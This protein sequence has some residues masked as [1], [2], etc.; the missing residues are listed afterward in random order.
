MWYQGRDAMPSRYLSG[1]ERWQTLHPEYEYVFWDEAAI[2]ALLASSYSEYLPRW[3][4]IDKVIKKCD[5]ARYFI[6]HHCG[7]VYADLDTLPYRSIDE[8]LADFSL[9]DAPIVL[10]EESQDPLVWKGPLGKRIRAERGLQKIVGNA[11]LLSRRGQ[12]FWLDFLDA[13]F[14][15]G[16]LPVLESF[17]TWHLSEFIR[18]Y[19]G[20]DQLAVVPPDHLL[21]TRFQAGTTYV[22]HGYD[23]TWFDYAKPVPWEG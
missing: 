16:D 17:S 13:S 6:L 18:G 22:V 19:P 15:I 11:I 1:C 2:V 10:S 7:G 4:R 21:A 3:E 14:L 12:G 9:T 23:A 20:R 8:F 5:A